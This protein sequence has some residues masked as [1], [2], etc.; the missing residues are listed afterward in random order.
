M[1]TN[2]IKQEAI[3]DGTAF[4]SVAETARSCGIGKT[5]L[6]HWLAIGVLRSVK[7]GGRRLVDAA[8]IR[9]LQARCSDS[10]SGER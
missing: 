6:Y 2:N 4:L 9:E 1:D 10:L 7:V 5:L 3:C 8:S